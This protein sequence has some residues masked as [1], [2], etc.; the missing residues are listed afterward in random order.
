MSTG[1]DGFAARLADLSRALEAGENDTAAL[2]ARSGFSLAAR[3]DDLSAMLAFAYALRESAME[4]ADQLEHWEE[5]RTAARRLSS[6]AVEAAASTELARL[7]LHLGAAELAGKHVEQVLAIFPVRSGDPLDELVSP[8]AVS[9]VIFGVL[10]ELYYVRDDFEAAERISSKLVLLA[11]DDAQARFYQAFSLC[12]LQRNEDAVNALKRLIEMTGEVPG[13]LISICGPLAALGR[14][15][16]ALEF[17]DRAIA[18]APTEPR[19]WQTRAL[20]NESAGRV[21]EALADLDRFVE[22]AE[23]AAAASQP[24]DEAGQAPSRSSIQYEREPPARDLADFAALARIRFLLTHERWA[25]AEAAA[26]PPATEGDLPTSI[27][28]HLQLGRATQGAGRHEDAVRY[29]SRCQELAKM[30]TG[31]GSREARLARAASYEA[32]GRMDDAIADLDSLCGQGEDH[33]ASAAVEA[34]TALLTRYPENFG[35]RKALGHALLE[36][37]LTG[38]A[39]EVLAEARLE[40]P[41]DWRVL[42]WLGMALVTTSREEDDWNR[43][44]TIRRVSDALGFLLEAVRLA[45]SETYP[46]SR[47]RWLVDRAAAIPGMWLFLSSR[48]YPGSAMTSSEFGVTDALPGLKQVFARWFEATK[49]EWPAHRWAQAAAELELG[50]AALA[51]AGMPILTGLFDLRLA[52]NYLRLYKMQRTLERLDA[53]EEAIIGAGLLPEMTISDERLREQLERLRDAGAR[54]QPWDIDHF[55]LYSLTLWHLKQYRDRLRAQVAHR[56]GDN[57]EIARNVAEH[58]EDESFEWV[59]FRMMALR[60]SDQVAEAVKLLPRLR[61]LTTPGN[62][63]KLA[64]MTA[65]LHLAQSKFRSAAEVIETALA[66]L[67]PDAYAASVLITN[68]LTAYVKL[69]RYDDALELD[70]RNPIPADSPVRV[71]YGRVATVARALAALGEHDRS[72]TALL[73]AVDLIDQVRGTLHGEQVRIAWQG[74]HIDIYDF[75]VAEALAANDTSTAL[76]LVER[77]KARAFVDLLGLEP[78]APTTASQKLSDDLGRARERLSL[79]VELAATDQPEDELELTRRYD[80]LRPA[81]P[82]RLDALDREID[83]E[84]AAVERLAG[85][86][87]VIPLHGRDSVA[88]PTLTAAAIREQLPGSC[89]LAEYYV[90]AEETVLFIVTPDMLDLAVYRI[91]GGA[92]HLAESVARHADAARLDPA[93]FRMDFEPY[94]QPILGYCR[95]E[96]VIVLVPH[97]QLHHVPLQLLLLD[98]NPVCHLPS[99]SLLRYR[100]QSEQRTWQKAL[101]FGDP[102]YDL[103]HA[104]REAVAVAQVFDQTAVLGADATRRRLLAGLD[105]APD[106]VHLACHGRFNGERALESAVLLAVGRTRHDSELSAADF[107]GLRLSAGLVTLSSCES[108]LSTNHPG[109]ELIGLTRA[110]LHTGVRSLLV[111]L[112]K[113]DDLSTAMLMDELYRRLRRAAPLATALR[114]AQQA[115][116]RMSAHDVMTRC[117]EWLDQETDPVAVATLLLDRAG[118]QALAGDLSAALDSCRRIAPDN[119]PAGDAGELR[120]QVFRRL[121]LLRLKQE[122]ETTVDYSVRPFAHPYHWAAFVLVGDWR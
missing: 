75:A 106:V 15:D 5:L 107:F 60:D 28:A 116:A 4:M 11:P 111:S 24:P 16:E 83:Q 32:L 20:L 23:L 71:R 118:V 109:D 59:H 78:A 36:D 41:S 9:A 100:P 21:D 19:Y 30:Y 13:P 53:A 58:S 10:K 121:N 95:P 31:V 84:R 74:S 76:D 63:A 65:S 26:L 50:R 44:F 48:P 14:T 98:R 35:V 93:A 40:R 70:A 87:A 94:I 33:D 49:Q 27:M 64:N 113:V 37:F 105:N 1:K 2:I 117:D 103:V 114:E 85:E 101:V 79:L 99:A 110:V 112:W 80:E 56:V 68:L 73:E 97:D 17:A 82:L 120:R 18:A 6:P 81:A 52:D 104:R 96:D 42:A 12:R 55:E 25:E 39:T 61:E 69:T 43:T 8:E 29:F 115:L 38:R 91:P 47:L 90:S 22:Q 46:V 119:L 72:L 92:A 86:L 67:T 108:G 77:S 66:E 57:A 34:L 102:R 45:P 51:D 89:V 88:G 7:N 122:A 54:L 62:E 3:A